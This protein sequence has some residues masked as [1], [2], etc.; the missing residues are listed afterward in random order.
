[1]IKLNYFEGNAANCTINFNNQNYT[2]LVRADGSAKVTPK[3]QN[4]Q[5]ESAIKMNVV[6]WLDRNY[7]KVKYTA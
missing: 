5:K 1:M 2:V 6:N 7:P 4:E 3:A